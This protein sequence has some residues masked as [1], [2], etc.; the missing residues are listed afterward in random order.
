MYLYTESISSG[1]SETPSWAGTS[2]KCKAWACCSTSNASN[3]LFSCTQSCHPLGHPSMEEEL[4]QGE[5]AKNKLEPAQW[6][7][8]TATSSP[9]NKERNRL[10]KWDEREEAGV[11]SAD[12]SPDDGNCSLGHLS[13]HFL[14]KIKPIN[15][16][17]QSTYV[18]DLYS[19]G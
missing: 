1:Y 13:F 11:L 2:C 3:K 7:E 9:Q 6:A 5:C 18:D 16:F 10:G 8:L 12:Q 4:A 14:L 19:L 15:V 17:C